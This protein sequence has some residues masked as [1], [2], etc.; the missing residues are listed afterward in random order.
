MSENNMPFSYH[1]FLFPFLWKDDK[2]VKT[3]NEFAKCL[4]IKDKRHINNP[5]TKE[6]SDFPKDN[7]AGKYNQYHYF[8]SAARNAIYPNSKDENDVVQS[9]RYNLASDCDWLEATKERNNKA[10][11]VIEIN[12][13][14]KYE[15]SLNGIRLKL[16]NSGI[17]ILIFEIENYFYSQLNDINKI[18]D[19]G[20]RIYMPFCEGDNRTCSQCAE[21]IYITYNDKDI[22]AASNG[23]S[24]KDM[25]EYDLQKPEFFNTTR[26]ALFIKKLLTNGDYSIT[27]DIKGKNN[28]TFY[29]EPVIDDRMFVACYCIQETFSDKL[30]VW[31]NDDYAY[32]NSIYNPEIIRDGDEIVAN[33][34]AKELYKFIYIDNG[35]EPTCQSKKLLKEMLGKK[36]VYD[37]WIEAGSLT[38]I[39][40][41]SLMTITGS[42]WD[43]LANNFLTE[44]I[45]MI[46]LVLAQRATLLNFERLIS[47]SAN[48]KNDIR[49]I[50]RSY[51]NFQS[52]LL[53]KEVSPQQQGI[54]IYR[55]MLDN[56]F[57]N[58]QVAEIENQ[59]EDSFAQKTA[60][61]EARE[62]KI[63]FIL[64]ILGVFDLVGKFFEWLNLET[65]SKYL[66][67][68][69]PVLAEVF[70]PI[71]SQSAYS[72]A[73]VVSLFGILGIGLIVLLF[74]RK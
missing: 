46:I 41:Y 50:H 34:L 11:Y 32:I 36:Y 26:I 33:N 14:Y 65:I 9:Y 25:A 28:K 56:L 35:Q 66:N 3:R 13:E 60:D 61:N 1:T 21:R 45:E 10:K 6:D 29:I 44:Y 23:N 15:L 38:G 4:A 47:D 57:I 59:I 74:K 17:G 5:W 63:L 27:T 73:F 68:E 43:V 18:N 58:E 7:F 2:R 12:K 8:N 70:S 53:L 30:K 54:E 62:N 24:V 67:T 19:F 72:I 31:E 51:L 37:R 55:M 39:T 48:N 71:F 42:T 64:A 40:E 20:R 69:F 49:R 22:F 16:F 52:Q